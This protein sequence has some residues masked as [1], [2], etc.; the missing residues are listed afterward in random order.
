[1]NTRGSRDRIGVIPASYSSKGPTAFD[2][3]VKPDIMAPGN[4]VISLYNSQLLLNQENPSNEIRRALYE[5]NGNPIKASD[6]YF[7]LSGTST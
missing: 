4:L 7:V 6:A 1:M 2:H 5:D 3:F